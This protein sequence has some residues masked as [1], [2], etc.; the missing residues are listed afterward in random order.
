LVWRRIHAYNDGRYLDTEMK[1]PGSGF[2]WGYKADPAD[3][4]FVMRLDDKGQ[5]VKTGDMKFSD[6]APQRT[7]E[8]T[9]RQEN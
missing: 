5:W 1:V 9:L 6:N 3:I 2:E 7:F 8:M 4:R